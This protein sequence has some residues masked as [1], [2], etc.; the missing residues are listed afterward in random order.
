MFL[1]KVYREWKLFFYVIIVFIAG[2]A[3]FM[4]KGIENVPFFLYHMFSTPHAPA[5]SVHVLLVNT[6]HGYFNT[7]KLS[8]REREMLLNSANY[9]DESKQ[10]NFQDPLVMTVRKRIAPIADST[11][12][13]QMEKKL[14]NQPAAFDEFPA[15][16]LRY[17]NSIQGQRFDSVQVISTFI[18]PGDSTDNISGQEVFSIKST[19]K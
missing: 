11:E 2:Q 15:W 3:F 7:N 10:R 14:V 4:F 9:Y 13:A 12:L 1:T 16:W 6:P 18:R 5:D 17:F 8:G 19:D